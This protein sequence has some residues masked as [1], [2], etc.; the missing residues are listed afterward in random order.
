MGKNITDTLRLVVSSII[1]DILAIGIVYFM[2]EIVKNDATAGLPDRPHADS[3]SGRT[4]AHR[5]V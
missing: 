1:I 4:G 3:G 2:P 5:P